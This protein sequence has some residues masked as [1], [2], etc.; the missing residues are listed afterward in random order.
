MSSLLKVI[1]ENSSKV[2]VKKIVRSLDENFSEKIYNDIEKNRFLLSDFVKRENIVETNFKSFK[3]ILENFLELSFLKKDD[4]NDIINSSKNLN[5]HS[6]L[7]EN[8]AVIFYK[9]KN[10]IQEDSILIAVNKGKIKIKNRKI[11]TLIL[12]SLNSEEKYRL[13]IYDFIKLFFENKETIVNNDRL[14]IYD[15]LIINI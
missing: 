4:I 1:L 6:F 2:D 5:M 3:E 10:N 13:L 11:G 9:K 12:V 8:T 7:N 15:Y 14:K